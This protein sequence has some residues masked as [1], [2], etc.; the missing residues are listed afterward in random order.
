VSREATKA[1]HR[2]DRYFSLFIRMRGSCERCEQSGYWTEVKWVRAVL[3]VGGLD[4]AHIWRR[5][6]SRT[7][8]EQDNA[9]SLCHDCHRTVDN[10]AAELLD[11]V[12]RTIGR[13][14]YDELRTLAQDVSA[15]PVDWPE[16]AEQWREMFKAVKESA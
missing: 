10:D 12:D 5:S 1:R 7:R 9:W 13:E 8:C 6:W 3:P 15:P 16:A 4:C 14:R 11:L 2:A